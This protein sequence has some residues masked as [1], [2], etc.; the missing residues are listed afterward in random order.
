MYFI[1]SLPVQTRTIR[2]GPGALKFATQISPL[3]DL[4]FNLKLLF[5]SHDTIA[6]IGII[7]IAKP[8]FCHSPQCYHCLFTVQLNC[9]FPF[10]LTQLVGTWWQR[11][12]LVTQ[13]K[14][15]TTTWTNPWQSWPSNQSTRHPKSWLMQPLSNAY[16]IWSL[17]WY[18]V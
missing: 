14:L 6:F 11:L 9:F 10:Q 7:Y 4:Q 18:D 13:T 5:T 2:R 15:F 3:L 8:L 17:T 16:L 1:E 12:C